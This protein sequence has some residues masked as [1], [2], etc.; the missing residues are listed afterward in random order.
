MKRL[1]SIQNFASKIVANSRKYDHV[2]P[3]LHQLSWLSVEQLLHY[4]DSVLTY[5]C[6]N[7]LA[8]P[9]YLSKKFI[10]CSNIWSVTRY[11]FLYIKLPPAN[12]PSSVRVTKINIW[13]NL[14]KVSKEIKSLETFKAALEKKDV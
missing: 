13:N 9:E 8:P 4:R 14:E 12:A 1:H 2:T 10:K 5:K 7:E 11:I 6:L 3:L